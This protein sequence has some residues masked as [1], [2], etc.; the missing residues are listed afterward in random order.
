MK[1]AAT[2]RIWLAM[3]MMPAAA[4]STMRISTSS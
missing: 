4:V 1:T 2:N 3:A